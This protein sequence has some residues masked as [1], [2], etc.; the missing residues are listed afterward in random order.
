VKSDV[1]NFTGIFW[2]LIDEWKE[3]IKEIERSGQKA[4]C[5]EQAPKVLHF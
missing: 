5:G 4:V 1:R 3:K 2:A